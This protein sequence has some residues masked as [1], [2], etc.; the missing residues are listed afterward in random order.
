VYCL[1]IFRFP[2]GTYNNQYMIVDVKKVR[3]GWELEDGTLWVVEQMPG[4]VVGDDQTTILRAGLLL[5][6]Y[7]LS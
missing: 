1:R 5:L 3:L 6:T 7:L 4:V 2:A